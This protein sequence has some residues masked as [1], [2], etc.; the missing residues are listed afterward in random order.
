MTTFNLDTALLATTDK[1]EIAAQK[2]EVKKTFNALKNSDKAAASACQ[3]LFAN[4]AHCFDA[5]IHEKDFKLAKKKWFAA[6]GYKNAEQFK[7]ATG[8]SSVS[9]YFSIMAWGAKEG[10]RAFYD[11]AELRTAYTD[12][13]KTK[14]SAKPAKAGAGTGTGESESAEPV[15]NIPEVTGLLLEAINKAS[16]LKPDLQNILALEMME[17]ITKAQAD[18][19]IK[20]AA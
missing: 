12:R 13:P 4:F 18:L 1:K 3:M 19:K 16:Q 8:L 14:A 2:R 10:H 7:E 11:F 17:A 6:L 20:K 9:T 15:A 5:E